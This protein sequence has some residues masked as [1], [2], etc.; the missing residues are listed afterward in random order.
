MVG[1]DGCCSRA[2]T[3]RA[4]IP[5]KLGRSKPRAGGS[6]VAMLLVVLVIIG[7]VVQWTMVLVLLV[8]REL[9][10]VVSASRRRSRRV[11]CCLC[12]R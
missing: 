3:T 6:R 7:D 8:R 12:S 9:T 5:G 2:S 4:D 10:E 11:G 1:R